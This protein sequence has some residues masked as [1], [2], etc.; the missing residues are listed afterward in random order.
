[1]TSFE[2]PTASNAQF[3]GLAQKSS[4]IAIPLLLLG[5]Y[6]L[7]H[8]IF[9]ELY[10]SIKYPDSLAIASIADIFGLVAAFYFFS[11]SK[12]YTSIVKTQGS[13]IALLLISNEQMKQALSCLCVTMFLYSARFIAV[14][15]A[16]KAVLEG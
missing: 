4:L 3:R 12:L 2:F 15:F 1:M 11:A 13:D 6:H 7:S 8:L 14:G 16:Y 5:I 10:S 9:P